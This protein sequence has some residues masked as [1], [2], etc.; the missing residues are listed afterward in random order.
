LLLVLV[1]GT[2]LAV[3]ESTTKGPRDLR[4]VEA[5]R[6]V[7]GRFDRVEW[8]DTRTGATR[9][10]SVGGP[11]VSDCR[12]TVVSDGTRIRFGDCHETWSRRVRAKDVWF[13]ADF[14]LARRLLTSGD[15]RVTGNVSTYGRRAFRVALPRSAN[16]AMPIRYVDVDPSSRL[17][18]RLVY[19]VDGRRWGEPVY[20]RRIPRAALPPDFFKP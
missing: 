8:L 19:S 18:I 7:G 16:Q 5:Y 1:A 20:V 17:P 10:E 2:A 11:W 3:P 15:A 6:F 12:W 9:Q 4:I 13:A 14:L